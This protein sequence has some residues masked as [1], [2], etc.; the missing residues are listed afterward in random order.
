M[1]KKIF[2]KI[3]TLYIF[4]YRK[5]KIKYYEEWSDN[6]EDRCFEIKCYKNDVYTHTVKLHYFTKEQVDK[7][8]SIKI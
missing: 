3:F 6:K 4:I 5:F 2:N 7:F 8:N 1:I